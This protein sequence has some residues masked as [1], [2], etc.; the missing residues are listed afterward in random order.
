MLLVL[1]LPLRLIRRT[2]KKRTV[3]LYGHKLHG[4]LNAIYEYSLTNHTTLQNIEVFFLTMDPLYFSDIK[5]KNNILFALNPIDLLKTVLSECIISD[6]GLHLLQ[7]LLKFTE[8]KFVDVWHG[9]PFK[10]F[11]AE[12][13]T[14]QR[15]YDETWVSSKLLRRLYIDTFGFQKDRVYATGY[16]RTDLVLG[17][18]ST[19]LQIREKL[20]IPI[21]KKVILFAPTWKQ[22][23]K[24]RDEIPFNLTQEHFLNSLE[25]FAANN[26]AFLIIRYHL[27]SKQGGN[28]DNQNVLHLPLQ[29]H[30]NSEELL[31]VTDVLITDWS[32]I[33]FDMMVLNKPIIFLDVPPPFKNGFS[34]PPDYRVGDLVKNLQELLE[35]LSEACLAEDRYLHKYDNDYQRV[36]ALVYDDTLDGKSTD[37]YI[38]QLQKLLTD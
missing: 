8:I 22:D 7:L 15:Q 20:N 35:S 31:A 26:N 30:P 36:K 21:D 14:L 34:L 24:N 4:N 18:H 16:G 28:F 32:S 3:I 23:K 13:F 12:D 29:K 17:Y 27:N 33:A 2:T 5:Y 19:S 9:I 1:F 11:T 6:H 10:G 25:N 38:S 37:R